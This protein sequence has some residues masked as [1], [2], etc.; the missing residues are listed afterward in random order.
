MLNSDNADFSGGRVKK[1][2]VKAY[3]AWAAVS[4]I[5]GTTFLAIR[6]AVADLPP[7]LFAGTRWLI[8]GTIL[9]VFLRL[10]GIRFPNLNEF[11]HL[12]VVG[13]LLLGVSHGLV[14]VAE[15]WIPSGLASLLITTIPFWVVGIEVLLPGDPKF[16]LHTVLGLLFGIT[17]V[18]LIFGGELDSLLNPEYF[19]GILILLAA[20][21]VWAVGS[22]YSKYKKTDVAP[23]MGAAAQ[24]L[25]A[26]FLQFILGM[27]LGEYEVFSFT[28]NSLLAFIY[29]IIFG[30]L[31]SYTSYIYALKHL[32][33]SFVTTYAYI[34]PVIALF[35]G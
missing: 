22:V 6:I 18:L 14:V 25:V 12:S 26:G 30:S 28:Q 11:L 21:F 34:N 27:L 23:L 20:V 17:G 13:I 9:L 7:M 5:W 31:I 1:E 3:W 19:L 24:M 8:A 29:L 32:P 33:V 2:I 35:L 16:N 15:I 4:I 10:C